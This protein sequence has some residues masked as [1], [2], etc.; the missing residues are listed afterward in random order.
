MSSPMWEHEMRANMAY[1]TER[2]MEDLPRQP[3]RRRWL[4]GRDRGV[5]LTAPVPAPTPALAPATLVAEPVPVTP[6]AL[7][8]P[9][10]TLGMAGGALA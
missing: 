5:T 3:R 8:V 2:L 10:P 7:P 4:P 6:I 1:R 9:E